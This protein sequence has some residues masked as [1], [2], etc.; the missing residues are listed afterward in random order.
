MK[1]LLCESKIKLILFAFL[2]LCFSLHGKAQTAPKKLIA[3]SPERF[4][5]IND[6]ILAEGM[7]LYTFEKLAWQA[8]DSLMKY[9]VNR[10]EIN[11]A[12]AIED[13][14]LTWRYIF[15]NLE[16]EQTVFE[17]TFHLSNDTSFYVSSATPRKLKPNEIELLKA[18]QLAPRKVIKE[19][20]DSILLANT[21]GLNWDLIPLEKG[22]YRLYLL[23]GTTKHGVIP[24]GDDYSF[25]LD[26]EM[27]VLSWRRYHRSFLEQPI[28]L[29][30]EE[31]KEVMHS[32]TQMTPYFTATD[33]ANYMLYGHDL[34]RIKK[35]SVLSTAF[36]NTSYL[37]TFDVEKMK[38]TSTVCPIEKH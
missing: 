9:N 33:I 36:A 23:H 6:S 29:N 27:N 7:L 37:T 15:A 25:D 11:S 19:K 20:G 3:P 1:T 31:I 5:A 2:L 32:H 24:I 22:G 12:T 8:T 28:T 18:K 13:G 38:L 4:Q 26:K 30:G 14:N 10:A 17:L 21:S 16:K 34:Y 35:F